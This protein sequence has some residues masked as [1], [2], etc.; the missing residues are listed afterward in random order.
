MTIFARIIS[1]EIPADIIYED[2]DVVAFRDIQPQAPAHILVVP[3]KPIP[4][5]AQATEEDTLL[6]GRIFLAATKIARD[7]GIESDGYR[8]VTNVGDHGGQS[9]FHL[10]V[11]VM[12]GRPLQ[13]PPG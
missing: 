7:I 4:S 1:G 8:L 13:W 3:R 12:G 2:Q 5:I 11:H 6:I 10:H 9:V